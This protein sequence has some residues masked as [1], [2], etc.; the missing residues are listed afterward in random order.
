MTVPESGGADQEV[1]F[2]TPQYDEEVFSA[3]A[4]RDRTGFDNLE[5]FLSTPSEPILCVLRR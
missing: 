5:Y 3:R 1:R 4:E 2:A